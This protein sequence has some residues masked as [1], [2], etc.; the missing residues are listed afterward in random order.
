MEFRSHFIITKVGQ[1]CY[2]H[3]TTNTRILQRENYLEAYLTMKTQSHKAKKMLCLYT[4]I[5]NT[6]LLKNY[7]D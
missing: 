7:L 5:R 4:Q 1:L 2:A 3:A 6:N